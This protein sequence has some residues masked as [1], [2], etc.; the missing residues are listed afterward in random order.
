MSDDP[1]EDIGPPSPPDGKKRA[2]EILR[3]AVLLGT[4]ENTDQVAPQ[5]AELVHKLLSGIGGAVVGGLI[6]AFLLPEIFEWPNPASPRLYFALGA[7]IVGAVG[8]NV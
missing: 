8:G 3:S 5:R 1:T 6:G 2:A 4:P 7:A